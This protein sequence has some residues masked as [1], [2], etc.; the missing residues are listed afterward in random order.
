MYDKRP[1][2][3]EIAVSHIMVKV[4][5]DADSAAKANARTKI[6]EIYSKLKSGQAFEDLARQFSDDKQ[7]SDR[8]GQL[9]PFKSGRLPTPFEDAAFA[10]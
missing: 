3:G 10:L 9:Q 7:T 4:P 5:K 6:N 8:G 1:T 2:R